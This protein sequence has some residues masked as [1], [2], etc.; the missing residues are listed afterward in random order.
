MDDLVQ[1]LSEGEHPVIASRCKSLLELKESIRRGHVL[2][3]FTD[4]QG[5]TELGIKLDHAAMN[6]AN[7]DR[8]EGTVHLV[9]NLTLNYVPVRCIADLIL[10]AMEGSGHLEALEP[11]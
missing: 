6:V 3:K 5:G 7:L 10:P 4:T 1:R 11:G 9:G 8:A 2:V